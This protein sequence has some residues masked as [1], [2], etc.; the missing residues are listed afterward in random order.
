MSTRKDLLPFFP[1]TSLIPIFEPSIFGVN[2]VLEVEHIITESKSNAF[3]TPWQASNGPADVPEDL[4]QTLKQV[5]YETHGN[6]D[7]E[8]EKQMFESF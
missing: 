8:L 7:P 5:L 6:N 4:V 3:E 2:Q 1:L